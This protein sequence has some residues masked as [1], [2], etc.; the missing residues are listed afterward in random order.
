MRQN[1]R[2]APS[3]FSAALTILRKDL[4]LELRTLETI[5]VTLIFTTAT[6]IVFHF[7]LNRDELFGDLAAG[8]FWVTILFASS[9]TINRLLSNER[10]QGGYEGLLLAPIDRNA[11]LYA[12]IAYL[13]IALTMLEIFAI[14]I[15]ALMLLGP[16]FDSAMLA[17]VPICLL[18]NLGLATIGTLISALATST[19]ARELLV[20]LMTLPLFIPLLIGASQATAPLFEKVP[21]VVDLGQWLGLM[22]L[23]DGVF[24]LL[25]IAV[26]EYILGD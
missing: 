9:L 11:I 15:Y 25:S 18:V 16:N 17:L 13:F 1:R 6:F 22:G 14:L 10:A 21:E 7:A 5:T 2:P 24:L 26:F 12:K 4:K 19:S 23:F 3:T 8:V 20:P